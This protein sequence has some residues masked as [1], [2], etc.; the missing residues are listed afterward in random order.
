MSEEQP[1]P[2]DQPESHS[3]DST[4]T[5][6]RKEGIVYVLQNPAM[7]EYIKIGQTDNLSNRMRQLFNTSV[8]VPFT[9][10]YAA[11]VADAS[12]LEKT[13]FEAFG[14]KRVNQ[15]REFFAADPNRVASVIKLMAIED[16]TAQADKSSD[17]DDIDS[18][19]RATAMVERAQ[20][21][22]FRMLDI[23]VGAELE[24]VKDPSIVCKV[25][26][27]RPPRV[28]F[29]GEEMSLSEA[30]QKVM[31]SPWRL[32]GTQYWKY[33]DETLQERRER[34]ESAESDGE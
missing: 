11:R 20:R 16:V 3:F 18:I 14:D 23:P 21:F 8:P 27:Q 2:I 17:R 34:M 19:S 26:Q 1:D 22:N 32:Q 33:E 4:S 10:F 24:F 9:C 6:A 13:L 12:Q 28:E 31:E 15:R 29:N 7:S 25:F 5:S 30:S